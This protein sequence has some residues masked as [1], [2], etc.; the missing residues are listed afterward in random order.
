M[1][2]SKNLKR[3]RLDYNTQNVSPSKR[4]RQEGSR[5]EVLSTAAASKASEKDPHNKTTPSLRP[6]PYFNYRDFSEVPD[7]DPFKPLTAPGRVPNFPAKMMAILSRPE[8]SDIVRW[9]EH[10]RAWKVFNPREFELKVL[11]TYFEHSKFS[12]FIRQANGWGFRRITQ[13]RDRNC[14]Y[15][16]LFL[17]G[18]PHLCKDM[19]RHGVS[20]KLAA[21]PDHEPDFYRISQEQ[22]V[23]ERGPDDDSI[24]LPHILMDGPKARMPICFRSN[25]SRSG[26]FSSNPIKTALSVPQTIPQRSASDTGGSPLLHANMVTPSFPPLDVTKKI[27][28]GNIGNSLHISPFQAANLAAF[29]ASA[30][31]SQF[32]AGFAAATALSQQH[33]SDILGQAFGSIPPARTG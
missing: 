28:F 19:K 33:Y 12:S 6:Y 25:P 21:D 15:N 9:L 32:A 3:S 14:Y 18:L 23:P 20:E 10:G 29:E 1:T 13:G 11:P 17:R 5:L 4:P 7:A 24:L 22:P 27:D 31:A 8:L 30:A 2:E 26:T 16:E